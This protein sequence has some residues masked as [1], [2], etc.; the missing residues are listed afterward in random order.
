MSGV[1][2]YTGLS[3]FYSD[4]LW[5]LGA[6]EHNRKA[7]GCLTV[8]GETNDHYRQIINALESVYP[9]ASLNKWWPGSLVF[10]AAMLTFLESDSDLFVWLEADMVRNE[11]VELPLTEGLCFVDAFRGNGYEPTRY[12]LHKKK[13][14][15]RLLSGNWTQIL[16]SHAVL[17]RPAVLSIYASLKLASL[18]LRDGETWMR[19]RDANAGSDSD[20]SPLLSDMVLELSYM[21]GGIYGHVGNVFGSLGWVSYDADYLTKPIIHFDGPHKEAILPYIVG[22]GV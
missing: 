13:V 2:F 16:A 5:P 22:Q 11:S 8:I 20:L 4:C 17:S 3:R 12:E 14:C 10:H 7:I 1:A 9:R 21:L 15:E 19:I 18:D 6:I